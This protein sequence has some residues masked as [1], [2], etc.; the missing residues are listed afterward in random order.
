MLSDI[1]AVFQNNAEILR[2]RCQPYWEIYF[3]WCPTNSYLLLPRT[4]ITVSLAMIC[5]G[6]VIVCYWF[7]GCRWVRKRAVWPPN[8]NTFPVPRSFLRNFPRIESFFL[9]LSFLQLQY[10]MKI[11][12]IRPDFVSFIY[13]VSRIKEIVEIIH[14]YIG[15]NV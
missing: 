6:A 11:Y 1:V 2:T 13:S 3:C 4:T 9:N 8:M 15:S 7:S 14:P 12:D 10:S 5:V